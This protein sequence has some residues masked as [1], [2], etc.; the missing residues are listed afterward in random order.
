MIHLRMDDDLNTIVPEDPS[1]PY[2]MHTV[3]EKVVD[4]EFS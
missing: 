4:R 2:N 1:L 3:I